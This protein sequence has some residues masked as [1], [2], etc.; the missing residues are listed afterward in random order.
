MIAPIYALRSPR[1][2][3]FACE[4]GQFGCALPN[5]ERNCAALAFYERASGRSRLRLRFSDGAQTIP[6]TRRRTSATLST[7]SPI[8]REPTHPTNDCITE[9]IAVS[10]RS[11]L[12]Q[13][14]WRI[15]LTIIQFTGRWRPFPFLLWACAHHLHHNARWTIRR[16]CEIFCLQRCLENLTLFLRPSSG[17]EGLLEILLELPVQTLAILLRTD[18]LQKA[19]RQHGKSLLTPMHRWPRS[20]VNPFP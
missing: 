1:R 2:P 12:P 4:S 20:D 18:S 15:S 14:C 16:V 11:R 3:A 17:Q 10:L 19:R 8:R 6:S 5:R 13:F 7:R 9:R